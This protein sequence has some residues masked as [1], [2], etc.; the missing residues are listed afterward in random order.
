MGASPLMSLGLRAM[1]A[2]Y[3]AM[4]ATG[5][6]IAN[7]NVTGYSRQ[8]AELQT[9]KGQY[10]G[11]GFF[12]KGVDVKTVTR[13]HDEFLTR[14]T[15]IAKSLSTMDA[16]RQERLQQLQQVFPT[17]EAGLGHTVDQFLNSM[18]DLASRPGDG[19]TRQ[20]VLARAQDMATRF[21]SAAHQLDTI[22]A[23]I[24]EDLKTTVM[25]VNGLAKSIA[26]VNNQI[27]A[28]QGTGQPPNDLLDE[29]DRLINQLSGL[30]QVSTVAATDGTTAVFVA[31]GQRLVL[32]GAASSL[33]VT[34]DPRDPSR[35]ALA[36]DDGNGSRVI[37]EST[38]GG[39]SISGL[40]RV[41][42]QDLVDGRNMIGQLA[43]AVSGA[44]NQQ[45]KLGLNLG[46][47]KD[48]N[49]KQINFGKEMFATGAPQ[50]LPNS[51]N[52]K[53]ASGKYIGAIAL[54]VIEPSVLQASDYELR[55]DPAGASGVY[56]LTRLSHPPLVRSLT[57]SQVGGHEVI[58]V[59][60]MRIDVTNPLSSTDRFLLQPVARAA[61]GMSKVIDDPNGIAA[62]SP[63]VAQIGG[64]NTGTA[65]L[66][67]FKMLNPPVNGKATA[68]ITFTDSGMY[69]WSL[70]D[71]SGAVIASELNCTWRAG[72]PIPTPPKDINGF[73]LR[74]SGSPN[75]GDTLTVAPTQ[76]IAANNAN[77][78]ALAGLRDATLIG[79]TQLD[80]GSLIG[81]VIATDAYA[82]D[83]A[84]IGVRVQT[85]TASAAISSSVLAQ[86]EQDAS[87]VSGVNLDEEAARL[88]QYQQ[89]Y[90]AAAKVLQVAQAVFQTL[91]DTAAAR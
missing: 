67:T 20:V 89:S 87:N 74:L 55:L 48:S 2:S 12:G 33:K 34:L 79:Q 72:E 31:G 30:V 51:A 21:N 4:Q 62:A 13:A 24:T 58:D 19:A 59:D 76:Y 73:E 61:A 53:D 88:I 38:L 60:G 22:Q 43:A 77:A 41:Q 29:R 5:H 78:L 65:D 66:V 1:T 91:L 14:A 71:E 16:S 83:M 36:L 25:E 63:L 57:S 15:T 37:D 17:G 7:A 80:D 3:M 11:A 27:A 6:N 47:Q 26:T 54:S 64:S 49:G 70:T 23:G 50:A 32:G 45:Q 42:N 69:D 90:Q 82:S 28:A 52:S 40:L 44:V 8:Q 68:Q 46:V 85:A 9:S 10:S 39:G 18:V 84:D 81:G 75:K 35:S 56:Q 86:A